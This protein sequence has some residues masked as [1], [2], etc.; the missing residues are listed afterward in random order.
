MEF[1]MTLKTS[2]T[3]TPIPLVAQVGKSVTKMTVCVEGAVMV[4]SMRLTKN[5][6]SRLTLMVALEASTVTATAN[7]LREQNLPRFLQTHLLP[8]SS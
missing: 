2:V 1:L 7:A 4:F 5:V 6:M 8:L 3:L